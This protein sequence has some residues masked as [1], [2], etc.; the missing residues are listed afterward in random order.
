MKSPKEPVA[1]AADKFFEKVTNLT[2]WRI[3][4]ES[5]NSGLQ[6]II[7]EIPPA[8]KEASLASNMV[9]S[10]L[11]INDTLTVTTFEATE[12]VIVGLPSQVEDHYL[13]VTPI[14]LEALKG[15]REDCL[16]PCIF[17]SYGTLEMVGGIFIARTVGFLRG[18]FSQ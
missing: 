6:E 13:I 18:S 7:L 10:S 4:L 17:G 11:K 3:I 5:S 9:K 15:N 16:A 8:T 2:P 12:T 14:I 1:P